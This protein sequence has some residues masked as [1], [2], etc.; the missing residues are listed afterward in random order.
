MA[1]RILITGARAPAA[2]DLA[3]SFTA[4]GFETHMSDCTLCMMARWSRASARVHRYPSPRTDA[5]GFAEAITKLTAAIEPILVVP[6]CEEV[7]HL[8]A[9]RSLAAALCAPPLATLRRLHSKSSFAED[10]SALGLLV[11]STSRTSSVNDLAPFLADA[12]DLVF[13]PEYSRFGSH[14]LIGPKADAVRALTPSPAA[15]WVVQTRVHGTEVSFYAASVDTRLVAFSAYRSTWR[16]SKGAGYA[17]EPLD[18]H[19]SGRLQEIADILAKRLIP[20]G[21]FA[22]DLIIDAEG[23]PWLI[24][25]NPRATSGVH[26]FG[27]RPE[28]ALALL[29]RCD[30]IAL[31]AA[32]PSHVG[33][34]LWWYGLPEAIRGKRLRDWRMQRQTG[35]EVIG[36]PGDRAPILGALADTMLFSARALAKGSDLAEV[37][38]ADIEWNGEEL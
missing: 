24:E 28:L 8:A 21:Q 2:L 6:A 5:P 38:T 1:E 10:C 14:T 18:A 35:G 30:E 11:P 7:F 26:L 13:K 27:R 15:P 22:C 9:Q 16:F 23:R 25:C 12:G 31:G 33:P 17:F 3:R 29:G 36:A 37:M 20:R 32:K 19:T 34:A 4:A